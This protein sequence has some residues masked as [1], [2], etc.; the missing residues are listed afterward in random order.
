MRIQLWSYNY[1]PEPTGI[2]P[3]STTF[4]RAMS[5]RGHRVEVIAAH[6]HYPEPR[7]G[8]RLA[9][10]REL[11]DG[12]S[13]LRVPL[14]YGRQSAAQR[15]RQELSYCA[16]VSAVTPI[17]GRPDVV[18]AASPSFPGLG[19]VMVNAR[20]RGVPWVLRLH[21]ILPDGAMATGI[22][23]DGL[24]IKVARR[25]ELQAYRRAARVV[26]ISDTFVE[27]LRGKGVAEDKVVRIY[28]PATRPIRSTMRSAS[29]I[30]ERYALTM[31]NVGFT[32]NLERLA[33]VFQ[34]SDPLAA[35]GARFVIAG[36][37]LAGPQVRRA[38]H[39]DRVTVTGVLDDISLE[40]ELQRA[41]V[42]VISQRYEGIDF[43]VPSKLMNFMGHGIPIV[44]SVRV[45]SEVARIVSTSGA[46]WVTDCADP[47]AWAQQL[48][49]AMGDRNERRRRGEAGLRYAREHFAP[50]RFA[51]RFEAVLDSITYRHGVNESLTR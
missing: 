41:S 4:A 13:V 35:L 14:W 44:A 26:V 38:I 19:P 18:V 29:G 17:I 24:L 47:A 23:S 31:G 34:D 46:G 50:E 5:E 37:G 27:N 45:E 10:Y 11:R 3:L 9:P 21:D 8:K 7:W 15:I 48:A 22:L 36:D 2:G 32:Q 43:N 42:A 12:I 49:L 33:E 16:A 40:R 1:D 30:D 51:E 20:M 39:T 25:F 28:D 6:P